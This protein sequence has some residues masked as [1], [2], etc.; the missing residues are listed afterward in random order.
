MRALSDE[1]AAAGKPIGEDELISF[2][3][4]GLDIEY[5][6]IISA[7]DVRVDPVSTDEL[8]GMISNFDQRVELFQGTGPG[9][10]KSSANTAYRGRG[11]PK[12]S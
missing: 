3:I 2:I 8:F 9:A 4:A 7:L 12:H 10:F 6:P 11:P 1:L 5:Q